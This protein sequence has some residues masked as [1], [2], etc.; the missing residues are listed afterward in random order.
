M[1]YS[2]Y[3]IDKNC[4]Q[5]PFYMIFL[6]FGLGGFFLLDMT[7]SLINYKNKLRQ[8]STLPFVNSLWQMDDSDESPSAGTHIYY[9]PINIKVEDTCI[10]INTEP[11]KHQTVCSKFLVKLSNT[12]IKWLLYIYIKL[13]SLSAFNEMSR[14]LLFLFKLKNIV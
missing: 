1:N 10:F 9:W 3:P 11:G 14:I 6:S 5:F 4:V 2:H 7:K 8:F 13:I 12:C